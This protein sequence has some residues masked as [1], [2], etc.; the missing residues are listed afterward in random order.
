MS[1]RCGHEARETRFIDAR[2]A[3]SLRDVLQNDGRLYLIFEFLDKD[4]K[5]YLDSCDGPLAPMLVKS[6]TLQML[7]GLSFC[8]MRG[9]MHRCVRSA[10]RS[11]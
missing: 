4:L 10:S 2:D 8:H 6:Y 11:S 5:R 3:R 9:V 1:G 7:R